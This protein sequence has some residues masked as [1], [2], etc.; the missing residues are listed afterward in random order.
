LSVA[1]RSLSLKDII[2]IYA[3]RPK[4]LKQEYL[5][6]QIIGFLASIDAPDD[7]VVQSLLV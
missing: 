4:G 5:W 1:R 3:S 7:L 6:S 2:F